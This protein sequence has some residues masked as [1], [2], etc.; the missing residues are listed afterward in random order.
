MNV[1]YYTLLY[2]EPEIVI[3]V[4]LSAR[5]L[6]VWVHSSKLVM[7]EESLISR[8]KSLHTILFVLRPPFMSY[9]TKLMRITA[10]LQLHY[11]FFHIYISSV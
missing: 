8:T 3:F 4:S 6:H 11:A 9:R 10:H 1:V 7:R 5:K 2:R